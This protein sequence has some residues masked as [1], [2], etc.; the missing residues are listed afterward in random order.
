MT[1]YKTTNAGE[2][3]LA[4]RMLKQDG[5]TLYVRPAANAIQASNS[6]TLEQVTKPD[7]L[8]GIS[9]VALVDGDWETP[10]TNTD[11]RAE[12]NYPEISYDPDGADDE[13]IY[14]YV[15]HDGT[16]VVT[17]ELFDTAIVIGGTTLLNIQPRVLLYDVADA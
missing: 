3:I 14:G 16:D 5:G 17:I 9:D 4:Q 15:I 1:R 2:L 6:L 12:I 11:G 7:F 10:E 13:S 8:D